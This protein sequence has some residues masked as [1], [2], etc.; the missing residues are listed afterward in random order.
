MCDAVLRQ[1]GVIRDHPLNDMLECARGLAVLPDPKG[2]NVLILTGAGGSGVLLSDACVDHGLMLMDM[3]KDLDAA[4]R[5]FTPP[6]GAAGNPVDITG[7]EPPSTY[8]ATI[9]LALREERI[10]S[11]ILGYWHTIMTPPIVFA[12]LLADAVES[13]REEG[14][15]KP[16]VCSLVGDVEVEVVCELL[17]D[18]R[19]LAYP[20]TAKKPVAVLRAKYRWARL[21]RFI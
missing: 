12:E 3:P 8:S 6:F 5:E 9:D 13:A 16:V 17:N 2:E 21:A 18:H 15:Y 20:Y 14:I 10:H 7:G 1:S 11:L 19:I 4:F